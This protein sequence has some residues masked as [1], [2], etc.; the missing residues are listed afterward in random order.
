MGCQARGTEGLGVPIS[1]GGC[2]IYRYVGRGGRARGIGLKTPSNNESLT[3]RSMTWG[4]AL[5]IA[6]CIALPS[7][8][9]VGRPYAGYFDRSPPWLRPCGRTKQAR[10]QFCSRQNCRFGRC[11]RQR[12]FL[13]ISLHF[14]PP[15]RSDAQVSRFQDEK[16]RRKSPKPFAPAP[17]PARIAGPLIASVASAGPRR[18]I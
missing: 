12:S 6:P 3:R 8:I 10:A 4:F 14:L 13:T 11:A 18:G 16:E 9:L 2:T 17:S 7:D 1:G 5:A 15:W